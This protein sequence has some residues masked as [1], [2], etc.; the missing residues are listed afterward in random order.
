MVAFEFYKGTYHGGSIPEADWPV[1]AARAEDQLERY[2]A[3]YTATA[4]D[5]GG[6]AENMAICAMADALAYFTAAQNEAGGPVSSASIGSVSVSYAGASGGGSVD[7]SAKGQA[8][9]LYRCASMYLE[10]Y[11]GVGGC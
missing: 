3:I 1:F 6:K 2:K 11:R 8:R 10:I 5:D 9:E 4:V 7:L